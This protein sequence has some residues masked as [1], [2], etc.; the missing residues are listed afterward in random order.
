MQHVLVWRGGHVE[1]RHRVAWAI[2]DADRTVLQSQGDIDCPIFPRSAIKP[3]Q[4]IPLVETGAADAYALSKQELA[5]AC[6][7]HNGEPV[8]VQRVEAWLKR[9]GFKTDSLECGVHPPSHQPSA[10]A[11][12]RSGVAPTALH[13]N[14]SGKH[15]GMLTLAK[16]LGVDPVGYIEPGHPVQQRIAR[17]LTALSGLDQLP[18]PAIDGCGIP[19]YPISLRVMAAAMARTTD[20]EALGAE[21]ASACSRIAEAMTAHP[22]MIAGQ[23]RP[24][25]TMMRA[26]PRIIAKT[27]AEGV[28]TAIWPERRLAIA[29]KVE[30][31]STRASSVALFAL[32]DMV[33]AVDAKAR[34]ELCEIARPTLR[35][36]NG[37]VVGHIET[38][39]H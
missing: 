20:P 6:A 4:A 9:V 8:H 12:T 32:L 27:G 1:S 2:V 22:D 26:L 30:D 15:A 25:T 24:C 36:R 29:L 7:S 19:T 23:D 37:Q 28:Y 5:L 21:R 39:G 10:D 33:G 14:C 3:L 13:N 35:N 17:T 11:L 31:G 16:H 18:T 34:S 38:D